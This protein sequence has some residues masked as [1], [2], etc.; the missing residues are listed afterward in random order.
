MLVA[1]FARAA[2]V[3][4]QQRSGKESEAGLLFDRR[5]QFSKPTDHLIDNAL[6]QT[7][8]VVEKGKQR[9]YEFILVQFS[10]IVLVFER[11]LF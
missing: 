6:S 4:D 7:Q 3:R 8:T 10:A 5:A 2:L 1:L 11:E 9:F